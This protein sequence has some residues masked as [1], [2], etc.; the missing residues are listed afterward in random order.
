MLPLQMFLFLMLGLLTCL[1]PLAAA[2]LAAAVVTIVICQ[3]HG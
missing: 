3:R 2:M 1:F